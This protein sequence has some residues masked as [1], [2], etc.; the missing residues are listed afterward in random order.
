MFWEAI[1]Y[2]TINADEV[3]EGIRGA[4]LNDLLHSLLNSKA[5]CFVKLDN[6]RRLQA[7]IITKFT[8]DKITG[9]KNLFIMPFFSWKRA[10]LEDWMEDFLLIKKFAEQEECKYITFNSRNP[11]VW[12]IGKALGFTEGL[13]MFSLDLGGQ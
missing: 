11:R 9:E 8:M 5:Q 6:E 4:Y 2:A 13:R 10:D 12:E 7:L 3:D 1:K